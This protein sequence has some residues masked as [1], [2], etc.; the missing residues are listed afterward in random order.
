MSTITQGTKLQDLLELQ[1]PPVAIAF[2]NEAPAGVK[3]IA[4]AAPAGCSYWKLAAE[5]GVFFTSAPDHYGCTVG[6]HTHGIDL[7]PDKAKELEQIVGT[8]VG[9]E[10]ISM[11]EVAKLPRLAGSFGVALYSPLS[12][13][14]CEP[15]VVLVRGSARQVMMLAEAAQAAGIAQ[16]GAV[17]GR[18]ACA[19]LPAVMQSGRS[20]TSLGCIGNRVYTGL[21]D[22]EFYYAIPAAKLGEVVEKL[23]V[24]VNA[25]Q[26]LEEFHQL[27]NAAGS[28]QAGAS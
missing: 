1:S 2:R 19:M 5:G 14:P 6:S 25:N 17:M 13:A 10:Y 18:P 8:M 16:E 9:L 7:P 12:S 26:K 23:A 21:G 11:E 15:D 27:R 28:S 22:G 4:A 24:I 3:Q 20:A